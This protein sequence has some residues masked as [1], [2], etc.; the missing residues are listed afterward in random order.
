MGILTKG[1]ALALS[2][3]WLI[4]LLALSPPKLPLALGKSAG[5]SCWEGLVVCVGLVPPLPWA[6]LAP[7][8]AAPQ[9]GLRGK[10]TGSGPGNPS[11]GSCSP[12]LASQEGSEPSYLMHEEHRDDLFIAGALRLH[13]V[14]IVG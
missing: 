5:K 10:V 3:L 2:S 11:P 1:V 6:L 13:Y 8:G 9:A 12:A 4:H 14:L 7:W